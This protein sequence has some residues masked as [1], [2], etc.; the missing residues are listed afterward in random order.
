M[1]C[2]TNIRIGLASRIALTWCLLAAASALADTGAVVSEQSAS[3]AYPALSLEQ[4]ACMSWGDLEQLYR[5]A[6]PGTIPTGYLRGRAIYCP[7][8][9]FHSSQSKISK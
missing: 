1:L 2:R 8:A 4:L 5:Q 9:R 3:V 7:D 6:S